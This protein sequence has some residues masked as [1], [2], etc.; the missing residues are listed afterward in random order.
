MGKIM[1]V[2]STLLIVALIL[3]TIPALLPDEDYLPEVRQWLDAAN[4]IE[5]IEMEKNSFNAIVGFTTA[6]DKDSIIEGADMV[7]E[8]N[9]VITMQRAKG[10]N[11]AQ[12]SQRWKENTHKV[13]I[14]WRDD[15]NE[16]ENG[17]PITWLAKN[18]DNYSKHIEKNRIYLE[19]FRNIIKM[20]KYVNTL[21]LDLNAPSVPFLDFLAANKLNNLSIINDYISDKNP[22]HIKRL[23]ESIAF[24]RLWLTESNFLLD[25][26]VALAILKNSLNT[27][28][29]LIN[30]SVLKPEHRLVITNLDTKERSML[31]AVQGE[32]AFLSSML[33]QP[34]F[35]LTVNE[36]G[37]E[38][39]AIKL[40][41][42][43]RRLENKAMQNIW[44][45]MLKQEN[46][47]VEQREK[48]TGDQTDFN[49]SWWDYYIDPVG[50][51]LLQIST[52]ASYGTYYNKI[53][54][55]DALITL[56]NLTTELK[57]KNIPASEIQKYLAET[58]IQLNPGYANAKLA[59][60]K[61]DK[62]LTFTIPEFSD[63][64][65]AKLKIH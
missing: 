33:Y 2:F 44:L 48:H 65:I 23:E 42:K 61:D 16:I 45:P 6:E 63:K 13:S 24:S 54:H 15:A 56:I 21:I 12:L 47:T 31:K 7:T 38:K 1:K 26:M 10:K 41:F 9:K 28:A 57:S 46:M 34:E 8:A 22:V 51:I 18:K 30:S 14:E 40:Y 25:K 53:D 37:I 60:H 58:K 19:R 43:P 59:W 64:N 5:A 55:V 11:S 17:D 3:A 29:A 27:Y 49:V 62:T 20:K 50:S 32:F 35:D 36:S 4:A 39:T 52:P